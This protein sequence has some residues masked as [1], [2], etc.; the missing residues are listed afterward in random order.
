MRKLII[1]LLLISS[2]STVNADQLILRN[3]N[4]LDGKVSLVSDNGVDFNT[5]HFKKTILIPKAEVS[6]ANIPLDEIYMIKYDKRGNVYINLDGSRKSGENQKIDK[7]A[8]IIY[9][10]EGKEIPAF[11]LKIENN[12]MIFQKSKDKKKALSDQVSLPISD[13]FMVIYSDKSIDVF[14][15]YKAPEPE[16]E[17]EPE[18]QEV[19]KVLNHTVKAGDTLNS[20]SKEY[21]VTVQD[22]REWNSIS[23]KITPTGRLKAGLVLQIYKTVMVQ[24]GNEIK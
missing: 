15:E 17:P 10:L 3:G 16:P 7:N 13:V 4:I 19:I 2:I 23:S 6:V 22:L 9:L 8:D 20:L 1:L 21:D 18:P 14:N 24:N 5:I 11:G 12:N